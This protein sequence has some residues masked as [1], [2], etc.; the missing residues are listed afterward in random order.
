MLR[1]SGICA[2]FSALAACVLC[3]AAWSAAPLLLRNPTLSQDRIAFLYADD[4]WMVPRQGGEARRFTSIGNVVDGPYFSPDGTQLAYSSS[5]HGLTDVYV[6][7]A[8][9][10]VPR[11]L[12]WEPTGSHAVGWSADGK[13]V[14]FSSLR[15]SKSV[16][17]RLFRV[18][19]DGVG[20]AQVLPLPSADFGSFAADGMTLA[21]V[22][23]N[24][25]ESGWKHYRGGQTTPIWLVNIKTLDV[26]RVP[27]DGSNDSHPVWAGNTVYFLSDRNGPIS[28]FSYDPM[29]KQVHPVLD[30][31][32]FDL[33]TLNAGP[34]ALVYEQFG[35]LHLYDLAT[36]QEHAV[37]VTIHGDLPQLTPHLAAVPVTAVENFALSPSGARVVAEARGDIF[38]LPAEKG[39]VRNLTKTPGS[40]ER[41]P[42][43]SPDGKSIAY[44]S[45]ASG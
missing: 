39:D 20:P 22:P 19:A 2:V 9:G 28:L 30:N 41:D 40:A 24:Q 36:H 5:A 38:T 25:W 34:G 14:L 32:G 8:D 26:E 45:D 6:S 21:Y 31:K 3:G 1:V 23:F 10:G 12:T 11:R 37:T 7:G 4:I 43:W 15:A 44:F 17:P 42:A 16:Y 13:E 33:K 18:R 29:L 27:R 35:S